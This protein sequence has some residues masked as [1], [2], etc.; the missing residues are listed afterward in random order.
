MKY[1][2]INIKTKFAVEDI[3]S[4]VIQENGIIGVEI[5]DNKNLTYDELKKMYVDIPLLKNNDENAVVSFYVRIVEEKYIKKIKNKN[6]DDSYTSS[7]DNYFT[8]DEFNLII[9][10]IKIKLDELNQ[11]L[12]MGDLN[13][14][15]VE[16]D[17]I[18]YL[19]NW[20][21]FFKPIFID[22]LVIKPIWDDTTYGGTEIKINPGSAF[23]TGQH[24]TTKLCIKNLKDI[25]KKYNK[26]SL[27]DIGC[28]SGILGIGAMKLGVNSVFNVDV[29]VSI[30]DTLYSN[31][32]CN[33]IDLKKF[34]IFYG[35][36]I[37]DIN[38]FNEIS[39]NK[40]DIITA[41]ILAPI[42]INLINVNIFDLVS[43]DGFL[44]LSGIIKDKKDDVINSLHSKGIFD[45]KIDS[46]NDWVCIIAKK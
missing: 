19:N 25:I 40:F 30:K 44:I 15:I 45:I 46:E 13:F 7:D 12:D 6:I 1:L 20:K 14:E 37:D 29:D 38:L 27:L 36:I 16:L 18:D 9:D 43:E 39:K 5:S 23:G 28:G 17:D 33:N 3:V 21:K 8:N 41:N 31:I 4:N 26:K 11:Y 34:K 22:G 24:E 2:K 10:N 32:E 35:N 42:I